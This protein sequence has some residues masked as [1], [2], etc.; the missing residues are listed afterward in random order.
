M[1]WIFSLA[2]GT[3]SAEEFNFDPTAEVS[4]EYHNKKLGP[5]YVMISGYT[6][7]FRKDQ[8]KMKNVYAS[9]GIYYWKYQF[10]GKRAPDADKIDL[11][12]LFKKIDTKGFKL[13][14]KRPPRD[15]VKLSDLN[16]R[17]KEAKKK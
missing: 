10:W 16:K 15:K 6:A 13:D 4:R 3:L 8:G 14:R 17:I 9:P 1:L 11:K 2:A 5:Y 7:I 12:K